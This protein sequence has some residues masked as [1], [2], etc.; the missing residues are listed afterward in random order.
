MLT[1]QQISYMKTIW[2]VLVRRLERAPFLIVAASEPNGQRDC[3]KEN[4]KPTF[5]VRWRNER[6]KQKEG[7]K[8]A[9]EINTGI[10]TANFI[11]IEYNGGMRCTLSYLKKKPGEII[12]LCARNNFTWQQ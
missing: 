4:N 1:F 8:K 7:G 2:A 6:G 9:I 12:S 10:A 5:S 11:Y 3:G